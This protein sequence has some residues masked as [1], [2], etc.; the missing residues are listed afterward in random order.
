MSSGCYKGI[1]YCERW[2]KFTNFFE[3]MGER[4]PGTTLDRINPYG[5]YEPGN[6]RWADIFTQENNRRNNVFYEV[7]G[8]KLTIPQIARK[9]NISRSN[10]ENK[11]HMK[12]WSMSDAL[13]YLLDR[14]R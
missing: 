1:S 13:K 10:L 6:C 7:E 5:N 8:E 3:D 11:I 4:P 12:K 14:R 2:E 9:Y